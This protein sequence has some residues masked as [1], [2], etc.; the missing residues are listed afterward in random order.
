[1]IDPAQLPM[2]LYS[3]F[4]S[5]PIKYG[6]EIHKRHSSILLPRLRPGPLFFM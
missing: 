5:G 2:K 6:Q 1:M 4:I 3:I